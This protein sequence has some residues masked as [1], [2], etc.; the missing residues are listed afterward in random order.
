MMPTI[1]SLAM[2][3]WKKLAMILSVIIA[4]IAQKNQV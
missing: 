4:M 3:G 1:V 2:Y